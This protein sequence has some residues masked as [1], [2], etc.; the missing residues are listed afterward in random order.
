MFLSTLIY[1]FTMFTILFIVLPI[2]L[3][4]GHTDSNET[5]SEILLKA[6]IGNLTEDDRC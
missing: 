3:I 2:K 6:L 4:L 1:F 5:S